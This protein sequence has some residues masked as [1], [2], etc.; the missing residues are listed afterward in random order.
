M[1]NMAKQMELFDEGGLM[2]EGGTVDPVSGN[3]VPVGSTQEEVR[4]DIPAQLSEGEFVMPADVVRYHGLDKMMALRDEAKMGLQR[5][6]AMGQMGNADEATIPDG[7]PFGMEDLEMED[8]G[9]EMNQGG[10]INYQ[11]PSIG[12]T[13]N[14]IGGAI[15]NPSLTP[16]VAQNLIGPLGT[17][18]GSVGTFGYTPP[19]AQVGTQVVVYGP[20]GTAYA[21]PQAAIAAGVNNY[22]TTPPVTAPTGQA[23]APMQAASAQFQPAGTKFTPTTIQPVMPTF[24]QTIGAGVPGVD[25]NLTSQDDKTKEEDTPTTVSPTTTSPTDD[26]DGGGDSDTGT[27]VGTGTTSVGSIS[28]LLNKFKGLIGG[29][30]PDAPRGKSV[31]DIFVSAANKN[32]YFGGSKDFGFGNEALRKASAVQGASQLGSLGLTGIVTELT[33]AAGITNFTIKDVGVAGFT[34][35]NQALNSMGLTNRGQLM[36]DRQ[37][38]LVGQAMSAAH[39]AAYRGQDTQAAINKVLGTQE[40]IDI[41]DR[42]YDAIKNAYVEKA[43]VKGTFTDRDFA[44]E[45]ARVERSAVEAERRGFNRQTPAD[46]RPGQAADAEFRSN[47]VT[48]RNGN[49]VTSKRTGKNVLTAAGK[50]RKDKLNAI[51][52]QAKINKEEATRRAEYEAKRQAG[53]DARVAQQEN[54]AKKQASLIASGQYEDVGSSDDFSDA[55]GDDGGSGGFSDSF[56]DTGP[57]GEGSGGISDAFGGGDY[58]GAFVGEVYKKNKLA[59]QMKRSGLASKK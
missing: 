23:A 21:N 55:F 36:N 44:N 54:I 47:V 6:D 27:G 35:M 25:F 39:T 49:P 17:P 30:D 33:K 12:F 48:D 4:D 46:S 15:T 14:L 41:Q 34:G 20:D 43:G 22:T 50:A 53:I 57:E 38:T 28:E 16:G 5:M 26:G 2:Q 59:S 42:A 31:G 32:N 56:G 37:A 40:A 29:G 1:A 11:R 58:K 3:D 9:L 10:L 19:P 7:V 24:Q 45:M 8:D 13:S 18:M 51:A 52:K